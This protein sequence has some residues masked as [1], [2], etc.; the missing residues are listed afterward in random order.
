[1]NDDLFS[2]LDSNFNETK[3]LAN[4]ISNLDTCEDVDTGINTAIRKIERLTNKALDT[5]QAGESMRPDVINA[6]HKL[7]VIIKDLTTTRNT[8]ASHKSIT[9]GEIGDVEV[10]IK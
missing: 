8:I 1:M 10:V 9:S 6:L 7:T 4:E 5:L 3:K 2:H